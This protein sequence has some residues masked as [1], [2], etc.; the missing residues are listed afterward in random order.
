MYLG[1]HYLT[2]ILAGVIVGMISA[3]IVYSLF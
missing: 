2:D 3:A 1:V